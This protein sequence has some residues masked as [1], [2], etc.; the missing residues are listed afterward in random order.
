MNNVYESARRTADTDILMD[1]AR[2][3]SDIELSMR[4]EAATRDDFPLYLHLLRAA[5]ES[6]EATEQQEVPR[7]AGGRS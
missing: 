2:L 5:E 7:A 1:R 3:I 6:V 4:P